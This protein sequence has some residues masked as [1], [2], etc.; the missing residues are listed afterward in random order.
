MAKTVG[1]YLGVNSLGIAI[2]AGKTLLNL[3]QFSLS[4]SDE[5]KA[6][7]VNEDVRLEAL[8]NKAL[9]EVGAEGEAVELS[10]ADRDFIFR[11]LEMPSMRKT[12]I[13][14]SL[15]YGVEKYI[16][17]KITELEWTYASMRSAKEKKVDI[18]FVGIRDRNLE[19]FREILSRLGLS[20][21][22]I[23]A[24][25][26]SLARAIKSL[27]RFSKTKNF[28]LLDLTEHESHLT[29]FQ[30]DLPVF[31][32]YL[33][34]PQKDKTFDTAKFAESVDFSFQYFKR[35]F[36]SYEIEKFIVVSNI[37]SKE[38][39]SSLTDSLQ[40][41]VEVV[42]PFDV[43]SREN[44]SVEGIKAFGAA[45]RDQYPS[46]FK[47][48]FKRTEVS[49]EGDVVEVEVEAPPLK[50]GMIGTLF[51]IGLAIALIMSIIM[52]NEVSVK[53]LDVKRQ[54][55][56]VAVPSELS[57]LPWGEYEGAITDLESKLAKLK[58]AQGAFTNLSGLFEA[59]SSRKVLP[60]GLWLERVALSDDRGRLNG[61]IRGYIFRDDDYQERLGVD[62]FVARL[63]AEPAIGDFFS[64]IAV[65]SSRR[66]QKKD[67]KVTYF[68][69]KLD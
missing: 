49:E 21:T 63:K 33:T 45:M 44:A 10:L 64:R 13:E 5:A 69:I 26:L 20:A 1:L 36:R 67:F 56:A 60:E 27:K 8:I 68:S 47:P 65:D 66:Q 22:N 30:N 38:L 15:V 59:L 31:N 11:S 46:A 23:E 53:A 24:S 28:A 18:A 54:R 41:P 32:R 16:P 3:N 43:V 2:A 9:R 12:E 7:V 57:S 19:R 62:D 58:D 39:A 37:E 61:D 17:F 6:E 40:T 25:A 34:I 55:E 52:G 51:G 50:L 35:E 14:S 42:T 4:A 29:F 48:G